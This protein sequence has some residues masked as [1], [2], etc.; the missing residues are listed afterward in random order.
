M[1]SQDVSVKIKVDLVVVGCRGDFA[2]SSI[3]KYNPNKDYTNV[4]NK[5]PNLVI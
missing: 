3:L 5:Y 2:C 1:V 4:H